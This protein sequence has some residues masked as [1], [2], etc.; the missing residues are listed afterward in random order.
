MDF[1]NTERGQKFTAS[2]IVEIIYVLKR[3][4]ENTIFFLHIN[5]KWYMEV[6]L[7]IFCFIDDSFI[8]L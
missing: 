7:P 1:I 2:E 3:N 8:V 4:K 5:I 6:L